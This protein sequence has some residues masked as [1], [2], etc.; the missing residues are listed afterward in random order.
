MRDRLLRLTL[1]TG[2]LVAGLLVLGTHFASAQPRGPKDNSVVGEDDGARPGQ[3]PWYRGDL[4]TR[5]SFRA[6]DPRD[7]PLWGYVWFDHPVPSY[8]YFQQPQLFRWSP[9]W[10]PGT[11][12]Y[13]YYSGPGLHYDPYWYP[14]A[15]RYR[16]RGGWGRW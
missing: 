12:Y 1:L 16:Y 8:Q 7:A 14:P 9:N 3:A 10:F 4:N 2:A 13:G 5:R 6:R 11:G 15:P